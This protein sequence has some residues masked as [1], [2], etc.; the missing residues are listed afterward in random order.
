MW[1]NSAYG[2]YGFI[3]PA[4]DFAG[5]GHCGN[6]P[7]CPDDLG[8]DI[9]L[10]DQK[11][12]FASGY[13][14]SDIDNHIAQ[15][16]RW[17]IKGSRSTDGRMSIG[18]KQVVKGFVEH[19]FGVARQVDPAN[20]RSYFTKQAA[21]L[22]SVADGIPGASAAIQSVVTAMPAGSLKAAAQHAQQWFQTNVAGTGEAERVSTQWQAFQ[23]DP[24]TGRV[25]RA[26]AEGYSRR[27]IQRQ[28]QG[29]NRRMDRERRILRGKEK[30]KKNIVI[31][32]SIAGGA[33]LLL[34][35]GVAASRGRA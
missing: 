26:D 30:N 33:V 4:A 3:H 19:A 2:G 22:A 29:W 17:K 34:L 28:A 6:A 13:S 32:A 7:S 5:C 8:Y 18:L 23:F 12:R 16:R 31:G 35:L 20:Y 14:D 25:T 21:L 11:A 27:N 24:P 10:Y 9:A 1:H 15:I